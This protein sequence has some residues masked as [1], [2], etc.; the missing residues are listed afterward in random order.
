MASTKCT[1]ESGK[2]V[3]TKCAKNGSNYCDIINEALKISKWFQGDSC[4]NSS[5]VLKSIK[6]FHQ[7]LESNCKCIAKGSNTLLLACDFYQLFLVRLKNFN[8]KIESE[9]AKCNNKLSQDTSA[10]DD[11]TRLTPASNSHCKKPSKYDSYAFPY[12][13]NFASQSSLLQLLKQSIKYFKETFSQEEPDVQIKLIQGLR[14]NAMLISCYYIFS[15]YHLFDYQYQTAK[16]LIDINMRVMPEEKEALLTAYHL[17]VKLYIE[18]GAIGK[19]QRYLKLSQ[20]LL[21]VMKKKNFETFESAL[22]YL[23]K[24]EID[25]RLGKIKQSSES[26][27][28][29]LN[30]D[31]L[32][33]LTLN[34]YYLKGLALTIASQIPPSQ[35]SYSNSFQEFIEPVQIAVCI[36]KRWHRPF[37]VS[38]SDNKP[39]EMLD[40]I[41]VDPIWYRFAI[42]NFAFKAF[43][44]ANTF[45]L[46]IGFFLDIVLIYNAFMKIIR[47]NCFLNSL[48]RFLMIGAKLDIICNKND[49]STLKLK[50]ALCCIDSKHIPK[51]SNSVSSLKSEVEENG[52]VDLLSSPLKSNTNLVN[53][54]SKELLD[55]DCFFQSLPSQPMPDQDYDCAHQNPFSVFDVKKVLCERPD[56]PDS[57]DET[58]FN[59]A[60]LKLP[61]YE[62]YVYPVNLLVLELFTHLS[63]TQKQVNS[64]MK[65]KLKE[66]FSKLP[67]FF[68]SVMKQIGK[69]IKI[70]PQD[71]NLNHISAIFLFKMKLIDLLSD[72]HDEEKDWSST[73]YL[74]KPFLSSIEPSFFQFEI[75]SLIGC[76]LFKYINAKVNLA[77][78]ESSI[79]EYDSLAV[80]EKMSQSIN[81]MQCRTPSP[82][83]KKRLHSA[84]TKV[85]KVPNAP[86][87]R[88][89]YK[90]DEFKDY[91][92]GLSKNYDKSQALL[93]K[94]GSLHSSCESDEN[95]ITNSNSYRHLEAGDVA[96][97]PKITK[98][99]SASKV[100]K[101]K[102]KRIVKP[103]QK[104]PI[105]N[106]NKNNNGGDENV[107]GYDDIL[108]ESLQRQLSIDPDLNQDIDHKLF[109][110]IKN[111][112]KNDDI[113]HFIDL[114]KLLLQ[115]YENHPPCHLYAQIHRL[116]F[117]LY[118][119]TQLANMEASTYHL[120]E[121]VRANSIRYRGLFTSEKKKNAKLKM[122]LD[123]SLMM[124]QSK[125][126]SNYQNMNDLLEK[127]S[128]EWRLV[129]V[130]SIS[131]GPN[132]I[133]DL[134]INRVQ[135]GKKSIFLKIKGNNN[136]VGFVI[137][138]FFNYIYLHVPARVHEHIH[139]CMCN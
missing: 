116:L 122:K 30:S 74:L 115:L 63:A 53:S 78:F 31:Y 58:Y 11:E 132:S 50:E 7:H 73:I 12:Y 4:K 83:N 20:A 99:H 93:F 114:L 23:D 138:L 19:A 130:F 108:S 90:M 102:S 109:D 27:K 6:I 76:L 16:I 117:N 112:D 84:K 88:V 110:K 125:R 92:Q 41:D 22:I 44:I 79:F 103:T 96:F 49:Y 60:N 121:S 131:N 47:Q 17:M 56:S 15:C 70:D 134:I 86:K 38:P 35:Y 119:S 52:S 107:D 14:I 94:M 89:K 33:R 13:V 1:N 128:N 21:K 54:L 127:V 32:N 135:K 24:C 55:E 61:N 129:Q 39:K 85:C 113:I 43:S 45:Y 95:D 48:L 104:E 87:N 66:I 136:K 34:R 137:C 126:D 77:N 18:N 64:E 118:S 124:F 106:N 36:L 101:L 29:F 2:V 51:F 69:A 42:Y 25:L 10:E 68:A 111:E 26:L 62:N 9:E 67:T 65:L 28:A 3:N 57:V 80:D 105:N 5:L 71:I 82:V 81:N 98:Q 123:T 37:F 91:I 46:N 120:S 75:R 40:N 133:P 72:C 100:I 59:F 97:N 8:M 139:M